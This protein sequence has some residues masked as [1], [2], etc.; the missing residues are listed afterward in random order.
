MWRPL[1]GCLRSGR[2]EDVLVTL[3]ILG[4]LERSIF[5]TREEHV[6]VLL[7]AFHHRWAGSGTQV[8]VVT[9]GCYT[10]SAQKNAQRGFLLG[11]GFGVGFWLKKPVFIGRRTSAI[12]LH[13]HWMGTASGSC[14]P[15][16]TAGV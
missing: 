1:I 11:V 5:C 10:R 3:D 6:S 9:C 16:G 15:E 7:G 8:A 13:P 12:E 2:R 4:L 14:R